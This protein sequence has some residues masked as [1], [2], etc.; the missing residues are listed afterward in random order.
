MKIDEAHHWCDAARTEMQNFDRHGFYTEV[1]EDQLPSWKPSAKRAHEV[2]DIMWV[3]G[4]SQRRGT[5]LIN[6]LQFRQTLY[7]ECIITAN[8]NT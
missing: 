2:I 8:L 3:L 6:P 1:S 7:G 4:T 5:V